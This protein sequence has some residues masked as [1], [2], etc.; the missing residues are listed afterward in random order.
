MTSLALLHSEGHTAEIV[1]LAFNLQSTL[2]GTGSVDHTCR[3]WDVATGQEAA[4][5]VVIPSYPSEPSST[6][7]TPPVP[8]RALQYPSEPSSTSRTPRTPRVSRTLCVTP[9]INKHYYTSA[10]PSQSPLF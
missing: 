1:C 4:V 7:R 10:Q 9:G 3:L 6:P 5:L 8:L 2:V